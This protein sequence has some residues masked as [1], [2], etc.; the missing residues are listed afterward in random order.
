MTEN[1]G[2]VDGREP[3]MSDE[4]NDTSQVDE[5]VNQH[6]IARFYLNLFS[7]TDD[8]KVHVRER[9]GITFGPK[10]TKR[11]TVE[12]NAF[13]VFNGEER[14]NSCDDVNT[15]IETRLAPQIK[16]LDPGKPVTPEEWFA[17]WILTANFLARSPVT[18]DHLKETLQW[19]G[20]IAEDAQ[21]LMPPDL[22]S[23]AADIN[24]AADVLYG[25]LAAQGTESICL[26]LREKRCDLLI[27]TDNSVFITS[28]NPAL[29]YVGGRLARLEVKP[30]FIERA[31]VEV[32]MPLKPNMACLWSS[33][34]AAEVRQVSA[35]EVARRNQDLFNACHAKVFANQESV[36]DDLS[37]PIAI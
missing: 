8:K 23:A 37:E 28:D 10:S 33:G 13:A 35:Q 29:V 36:L 26:S 17:V 20:M 27:A 3:K 12:E 9:S 4:V 32:F 1:E 7:A 5:N 34:P 21:P 30:G 18:R 11:L 24:R 15:G 19:A 14:D 22:E 6:T 16:S 2:A 25:V 31:D